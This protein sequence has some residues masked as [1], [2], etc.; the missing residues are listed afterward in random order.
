MKF[1]P[2]FD[3][4]GDVQ[5]TTRSVDLPTQL[6]P[7]QMQTIHPSN[8]SS[9]TRARFSARGDRIASSSADGI[10]AVWDSSSPKSAAYLSCGL[11]VTAIDWDLKNNRILAIGTGLRKIRL[12]NT[13]SLHVVEDLY[14]SSRFQRYIVHPLLSFL[15]LIFVTVY[16]PSRFIFSYLHSFQN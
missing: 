4:K 14:T 16:V 7:L 8:K 9:V 13:Q 3:G 1:H 5:Y 10:V 2:F 6:F 15:S 12:W 11:Q